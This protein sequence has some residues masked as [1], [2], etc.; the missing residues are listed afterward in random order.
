VVGKLKWWQIAVA[1]LEWLGVG[2]VENRSGGELELGVGK[3]EGGKFGVVQA[4]FRWARMSHASVGQITQ[5]GP[6]T[7]SHRFPLQPRTEQNT[8]ET[9]NEH[10]RTRIISHIR[11]RTRDGQETDSITHKTTKKITNESRAARE[12]SKRWKN[13]V[14]CFFAA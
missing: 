5:V 4:N 10:T 13:K 8:N 12:A 2:V 14:F 3:L 9:T 6:C 1:K 7:R 11:W